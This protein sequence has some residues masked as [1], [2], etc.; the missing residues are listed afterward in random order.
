MANTEGAQQQLPSYLT[1]SLIQRSLEH[2]LQRPVTIDRFTAGPATAAG[3]NYLSDVFW[4]RVE[5]DGG[6][7]EKR[8]IA[9][10]MPDVGD[11][12][13]T[14][15]VLDAFRKESETFQH[16]LPEF[17]RL[18]S[19]DGKEQF[20]AKCYY[21]TTEPVRTIVFED[22]KALGFR[23]CDRT[24]GGLDFDHMAL[25]MRKIAKF[26]GASMLYAKQSPEHERRLTSRY[27]YGLYNPMEKPEECRILQA[28]EKGL[29][30]FISVA[31]G[32][33]ELDSGVLKQLNVIRPTFKERIAKCV[34]PQQS[35]ARYKALNHG[36]LW[37]NNMMFRYE[38][39]GSTVREIM[40]VDYQI[41]TYGSPGLDL[42]YTLYNCPHRDVRLDR[43][44]ELLKEYHQVL[45]ETLKRKHYEPLP[46]LDDV[47]EE[48]TRNEFFGLVC[49]ITFLPIMVMERSDD[50]DLSFDAF[51]KEEHGERVRDVQ[52]NGAAFREVVVPVLHNLHA[53]GFIQ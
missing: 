3:D 53:R 12:G 42:V 24:K 48:F 27:S 30:K 20:G 31:S 40:F 49:A 19:P 5:Y 23:M 16:L 47:K 32:W 14:L 26:H 4:I 17:S 25:V 34:N 45:R 46:T 33:P 1:E 11:R 10:C 37:S 6:A 38:K 29:D 50:L 44:E 28:L 21:A 13:A 39:D 18:I 43:R 36:D 35:G 22:L 9:K 15:D 8:L 41:S 51:F 2:D 52:Y 7:S